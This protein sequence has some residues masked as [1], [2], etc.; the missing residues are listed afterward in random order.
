M[1]LP[2]RLAAPQVLPVEFLADLTK[3]DC[4]SMLRGGEADATRGPAA[5]G[6]GAMPW[7]TP[8]RLD[9]GA[10]PTANGSSAQR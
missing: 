6:K 10:A 2:V 9:K 1:P 8:L 5:V 4:L 3:R 7:L